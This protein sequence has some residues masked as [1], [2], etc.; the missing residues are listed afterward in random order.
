M[1]YICIIEQAKKRQ[2][3]NLV[4]SI[5]MCTKPGLIRP[6][7]PLPFLCV[8]LS[9]NYHLKQ[10][11]NQVKRVNLYVFGPKTGRSGIF[12]TDPNDP[13]MQALF[14]FRLNRA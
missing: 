5:L 11:N 4:T 12:E 10:K 13:H 2:L 7:G 1:L 3:N 14:E 8:F 6:N 9:L